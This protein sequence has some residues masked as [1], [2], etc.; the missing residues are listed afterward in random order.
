LRAVVDGA[1]LAL[2]AEKHRVLLAALLLRANQVV[3]M[4]ELLD[5]LWADAPPPG[6]RAAVHTYVHRLRR[7]FG[8]PDTPATAEGRL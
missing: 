1:A 2:P 7:A 4:S 5:H 8:R 3:P 6:A